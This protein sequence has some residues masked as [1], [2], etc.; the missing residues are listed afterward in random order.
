MACRR[1]LEPKFWRKL[2]RQLQCEDLIAD[3]FSPEP[4]Q[5]H[6]KERLASAF[7]TRTA[8]EWFALLHEHDCCV[9][10]VRTLEEAVTDKRFDPEP[11]TVL[12]DTRGEP[13]NV[14]LLYWASIRPGAGSF[15]HNTEQLRELESA[16]VI[17]VS[18][19]PSTMKALSSPL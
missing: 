11:S 9:T 2:C 14:L 5:C 19:R 13:G 10:P 1:R 6:L 17:Q 3:Q 12:S 18:K 15:G 4:R 16:G 8:K 7:A